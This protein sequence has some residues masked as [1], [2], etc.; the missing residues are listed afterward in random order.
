MIRKGSLKPTCTMQLSKET[1]TFVSCKCGTIER[2]QSISQN[3]LQ[4]FVKVV[5]IKFSFP[6]IIRFVLA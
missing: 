3:L 1:A 2:L 5:V 6:D 4:I